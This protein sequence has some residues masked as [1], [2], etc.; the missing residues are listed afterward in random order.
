MADH[1]QGI[2]SSEK[3]IDPQKSFARRLFWLKLG[4]LGLFAV[5]VLRE[6]STTAMEKRWCRIFS[7]H[8]LESTRRW[9]GMMLMTLQRPSRGLS[10]NHEA[11][12][13]RNSLP[14]IG[15]LSGWSAR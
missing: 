15:I 5:V 13:W 14:G 12:I 6:I 7:R 4:L 2:Y 1:V 11:S 10:E 8:H 9:W 3:R